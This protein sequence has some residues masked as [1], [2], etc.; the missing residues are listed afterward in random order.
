MKARTFR[1]AFAE[2]AGGVLGQ[3]IGML[4]FLALFAAASVTPYL[5]GEWYERRELRRTN[6]GQA[7]EAVSDTP[8]QE[9]VSLRERRKG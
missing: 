7:D 3:G 8:A 2:E 4:P 9:P 5:I 1:Q 6:E